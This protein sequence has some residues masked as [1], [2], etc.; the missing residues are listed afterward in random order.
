MIDL[1]G[2][3]GAVLRI[4]HRGAATL[5]PENTLHAFRA[6]VEVGVDVIEFDV[7]D[8]PRGPLVLAHSDHLEE[9]SHGAARG[10]VRSPS[11]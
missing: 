4:G 10:R 8:L 7:L 3:S 5:A 1:R 11:P 9:V 2:P 6:A